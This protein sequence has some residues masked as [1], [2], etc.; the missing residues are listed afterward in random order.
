MLTDGPCQDV[1]C[2]LQ[3]SKLA[4]GVDCWDVK[5]GMTVE[6]AASNS[7]AVG[8]K[9]D[10]IGVSVGSTVGTGVSVGGISVSVGIAACVSATIVKA[11]AIAVDCT[12][13]A[14]DVG[15]R[16]VDVLHALITRL[17]ITIPAHGYIFIMT[18]IS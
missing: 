3:E 9:N 15:S 1:R 13:S 8:V 18:S 2:L 11:A 6:V 10:G 17:S 12:L 7:K 5:V 14:S 4:A 16:G